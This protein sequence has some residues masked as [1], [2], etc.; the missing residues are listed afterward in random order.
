MVDSF[1]TGSYVRQT[2]IRPLK[3]VDF[4][5]VLHYGKH[6]D[7]A[8]AYLLESLRKVLRKSYPFSKI[9]V[10]PPCITLCFQY[11]DFEIVPAFAI[12]DND[13]KYEIPDEWGLSW[14]ITYPKIP[15]IWMTNENK[16]AGGLFKPVIKVIK[17]WRDVKKVPLRSFHLEMLAR[18]AFNTYKADCYSLTLGVGAF[19]L[20]TYELLSSNQSP[21]VKEP[22][23]QN[24]YV[25]QYLF[26]D[27]KAH[28]AVSEQVKLACGHFSKAFEASKKGLLKS[29]RDHFKA[30]FGDD[31]SGRSLIT[32]FS[33]R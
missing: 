26:D 28:R 3:D 24:V 21:F 32:L 31:F 18:Y 14:K 23:L 19:F 29:A 15:D 9:T 2:M 20:N 12:K 6:K 17:K 13:H 27:A 30:I 11:C 4:I 25:D 16:D 8:P 7:A 22:N 10:T 1:L 5:A 33:K